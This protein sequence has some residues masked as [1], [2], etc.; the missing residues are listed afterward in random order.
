MANCPSRHLSASYRVADQGLFGWVIWRTGI[1]STATS[2]PTGVVIN[3]HAHG[4]FERGGYRSWAVY[5]LLATIKSAIC[6][7]S[8]TGVPAS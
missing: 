5:R 4:P 1:A 3:S 6:R 7:C 8:P 2:T